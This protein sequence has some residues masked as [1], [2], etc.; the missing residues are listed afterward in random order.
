MDWTNEE[1]LKSFNLVVRDCKNMS[2][3]DLE[4]AHAKFKEDHRKLYEVAIDSVINNKVQESYNKLKMML[5]AK[6]SMTQ[7]K[8]S[9]LHTDMFVGNQLANEYIYPVTNKP[10]NEDMIKA[11]NEITKK[12]QSE[13]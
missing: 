3:N 1:I 12:A 13:S 8:V 2:A 7:G 5:K 6:D 10:S 11:I 9:K 4:K